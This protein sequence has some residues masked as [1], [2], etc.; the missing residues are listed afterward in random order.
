VTQEITSNKLAIVGQ[1]LAMFAV[2]AV[3]GITVEYLDLFESS[4]LG[5][6]SASSGLPLAGIAL[7]LVGLAIAVTMAIDSW[8]FKLVAG[9]TGIEIVERLGKTRVRYDNIEALTLI[10]AYG[11]GIALKD[12]NEWLNAFAGS[13]SNRDKLARISAVLS[14]A[15]GCDIAFVNKRLQCGSK[16]FLDLLSAKTGLPVSS[17]KAA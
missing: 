3:G 4:V 5:R 12:K 17:K 16:A 9:D 11:A 7:G 8:S 10:P 1:S 2:F 15:Y 6:L 13:A 14:G